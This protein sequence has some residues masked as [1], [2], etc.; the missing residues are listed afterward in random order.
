MKEPI[1]VEAV[2]GGLSAAVDSDRL[3]Q[4]KES[5]SDFSRPSS[6]APRDRSQPFVPPPAHAGATTPSHR[7][8]DE[9]DYPPL[10]SPPGFVISS[11]VENHGRKPTPKECADNDQVGVVSFI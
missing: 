6:Q 4:T 2:P 10:V 8:N 11:N 3:A 1:V 9:V 5:P 7:F